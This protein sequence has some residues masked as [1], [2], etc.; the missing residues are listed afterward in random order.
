MRNSRIVQ[1]VEHTL[2]GYGP[3]FESEFGSKKTTQWSNTK[4][5]SALQAAS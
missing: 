4:A 5:Y 2:R 3:R 1:L